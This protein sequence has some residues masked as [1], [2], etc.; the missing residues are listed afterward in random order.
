MS[1]ETINLPSLSAR[2]FDDAA[3]GK[4]KPPEIATFVSL[5]CTSEILQPFQQRRLFDAFW[6]RICRTL[7]SGRLVIPRIMPRQLFDRGKGGIL[8]DS[9]LFRMGEEG[10]IGV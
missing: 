1:G 9:A 7:S 8:H 2:S 5:A 10:V 3:R 4:I 6:L